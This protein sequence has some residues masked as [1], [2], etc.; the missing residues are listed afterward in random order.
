M[1]R[2]EIE[3][4]LLELVG[5]YPQIIWLKNFSDS[6]LYLER[7][8]NGTLAYYLLESGNPPP[9]TQQRLSWCQEAAKAVT[10]VHS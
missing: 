4:K 2:L 9:S 3:R 6:G 1:N 5:P 8:M 7:V 10:H